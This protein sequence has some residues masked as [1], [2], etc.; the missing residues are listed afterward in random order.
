MVWKIQER[1]EMD[2]GNVEKDLGKVRKESMEWE[3]CREGFRE[4]GQGFRE[5]G[6][7]PGKC[8]KM[9]ERWERIQGKDGKRWER[10]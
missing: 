1:W 2:E 9:Q 8:R 10:V 7:D 6:K 3:K 5:E 4:C